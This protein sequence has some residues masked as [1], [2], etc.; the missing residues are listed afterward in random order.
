MSAS[1]VNLVRP[2]FA[3]FKDI[4]NWMTNVINKEIKKTSDCKKLKT[5]QRLQEKCPNAEIFL[6]CVFLKNRLKYGELFS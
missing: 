1:F 2:S 6:W 3:T 5:I 4:L